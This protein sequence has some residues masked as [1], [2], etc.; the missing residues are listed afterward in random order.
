MLKDKAEFLEALN[1]ITE[2]NTSDDVLDILQFA[3]AIDTDN[4]EKI[5]EL[6]QQITDLQTEKDN[7]DNTWR[8]KYRNAFFN[9]PDQRKQPDPKTN[10]NKGVTFKDLFKTKE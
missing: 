9:P 4:S 1:K 10:E 5:Q 2:G 3:T 6:E 7:L 8:E